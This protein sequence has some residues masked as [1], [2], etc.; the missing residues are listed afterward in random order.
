MNIYQIKQF[1][2]QYKLKLDWERNTYIPKV[3]VFRVLDTV[4]TMLSL[5][6]WLKSRDYKELADRIAKL[7]WD[8]LWS[9]NEWE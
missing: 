8:D 1:I 9:K 4:Y 3:E 7:D 5:E 6:Q 2:Y